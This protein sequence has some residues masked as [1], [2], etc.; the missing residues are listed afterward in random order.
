QVDPRVLIPRPETE[1]LVDLV[2]DFTTNDKRQT[3]NPA[4]VDVGTG[5]G[6]IALTLAKHLPDAQVYALDISPEALKVAQTNA[7][8]LSI[9]KVTFLQ[10]D[11]LQ[12]LTDVLQPNSVDVIVAN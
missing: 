8:L 11:L 2:L 9:P 5:S 1:A 6:C 3:T 10:G 4:I 7:R 12:P